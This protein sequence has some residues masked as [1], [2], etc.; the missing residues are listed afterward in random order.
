[1]RHGGGRED[2]WSRDG[3][4]MEE[5]WR[6]NGGEMEQ[7]WMRVGGELNE[8]WIRVGGWMEEAYRRHGGG[9]EDGW[10]SVGGGVDRIIIEN[11]APRINQNGSNCGRKSQL[12]G[13]L[14]EPLNPRD[15]E[16]KE[17]DLKFFIKT[18][19]RYTT[20]F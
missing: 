18:R 8:G 15:W 4:G 20:K 3:G 10:R 2:G 5:T 7:V 17:K 11:I 6:R 19:K 13:I 14:A 9:L 16:M 1:M 12:S